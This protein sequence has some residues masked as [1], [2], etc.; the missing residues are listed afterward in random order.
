MD[1]LHS[2]K[3]VR[4]TMGEHGLHFQKA[5]GQNFLTD[6]TVLEQIVDAAK[7]DSDTCVLEIG[8]GAGT[9]TRELAQN[10][11]RVVAVEIDKNLIP[12]LSENTAEFD[13]VKIINQDILKTDLKKLFEE[14]FCGKTVKV[15]ANLP[16]YITTPIIMKLLEENPGISSIVIMIQKEVAERLCAEPGTKAYGAVTLSVNYYAKPSFVCLVPPESFVPPPKVWSAVLKLDVLGNPPV[17]VKDEKLFFNLIKAAFGQRR[18]TFINSAGN[19]SGIAFDKE[20]IKN[21]LIKLGFSETARGETF[22][23]VNFS[24]IANELSDINL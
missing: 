23:L 12:M 8:P 7:L 15:V 13:N 22:S 20:D 18:K 1:K 9:L 21:V 19:F 2:S 24:Q 5:L 11:Y 14:E 6:V 17:D 10:A 16:Y 4:K 3:G